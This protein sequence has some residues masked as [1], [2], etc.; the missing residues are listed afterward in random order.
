M[1][2]REAHIS[3]PGV[4]IVK[5]RAHPERYS[6]NTTT[7]TQHMWGNYLADHAASEHHLT[8]DMHGIFNTLDP[9]VLRTS[10]PSST[11]MSRVLVA[12][13]LG[14]TDGSTGS[15]TRTSLATLA[16]RSELQV[17]LEQREIASAAINH[18]TQWSDLNLPFSTRMLNSARI[19]FSQRAGTLRTLWDKRWHGRNR[20]KIRDLPPRAKKELQACPYCDAPMDDEDHWIRRCQ[21]T[22]LPGMREIAISNATACIHA[23]QGALGNEATSILQATLHHAI[24]H[25]QGHKIWSG[26]WSKELRQAVTT[27]SHCNTGT[28]ET[29]VRATTKHLIAMCRVLNS[30]SRDLWAARSDLPLT[31]RVIKFA[32][33]LPVYAAHLGHASIST[34]HTQTHSMRTPTT[35]STGFRRSIVPTP[36]LITTSLTTQ[37]Q[38]DKIR[39]SQAIT[40]AAR[41]TAYKQFISTDQA[42][43]GRTHAHSRSSHRSRASYCPMPT[44]HE[45][46]VSP[47]LLANLFSH[48]AYHTHPPSISSSTAPPI[49]P[50]GDG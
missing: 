45:E 31:N 20:S 15:P 9:R 49:P 48:H 4:K 14:W 18:N 6:P 35:N 24:S 1:A 10:I 43:I 50:F 2:N 19:S 37:Q 23:C 46:F 12:N 22:P 21:A 3:S 13:K 38:L 16:T 33:E 11:I 36:P 47:V 42:Q 41:D 30:A 17:Y 5:V 40:N 44:I 26:L 34:K 29:T 32:T 8:P 39:N 25:P 7:W 28:P 27:D